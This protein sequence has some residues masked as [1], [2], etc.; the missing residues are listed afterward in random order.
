VVLG[1]AGVGALIAVAMW[2]RAIAVDTAVVRR[3]SIEVTLDEDGQTR[4]RDRFVVAAPVTGEVRRISLRPGDRVTRGADVASLRPAVTSPLDART[5][6]EA[7]AALEAAEA[8]LGRAT[9]EI[10]RARTARDRAAQ[11]VGRTRTLAQAGAVSR[12]ELEARQTELD[13]AEAAVRAAEFARAQAEHEVAAARARLAPAGQTTGADVRVVAPI[14]GVVLRRYRESQS[15]VPAGEPLMEIGDPTAIEIVADFLSADAV[16]IRPGQ[17]VRIEQ[18][19]GDPLRG[20]VRRVE[21]SGFTRVSALGVEEQR[22]N[23]LIDFDAPPDALAAIR[24]NFRVEVRVIVAEHQGILTLPL[25]SLFRRQ[26]AWAVYAVVDGRAA[27]RTVDVGARSR[28][29]AEVVSGLDEGAVVVL[30][31]PDTLSDGVRVNVR[32]R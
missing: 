28:T 20:R 22:V 7:T 6:A 11:Q 15:V 13:L 31:P 18:W 29:D 2:P 17:A 32:L 16:R 23:V 12:E 27:L 21:P 4:V 9:T 30:Y 14:S 1:V 5:R 10:G 26:E 8:A 3:G 24:D 25:G 19:G